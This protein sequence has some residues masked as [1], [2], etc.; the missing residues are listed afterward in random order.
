MILHQLLCMYGKWMGL[1]FLFVWLFVFLDCQTGIVSWLSLKLKK[2][3][4]ISHSWS[5]A[6]KWA[7]SILFKNILKFPSAPS[8]CLSVWSAFTLKALTFFLS[9]I[10]HSLTGALVT[11]LFTYLAGGT[12]LNPGCVT[13]GIRRKICSKSIMW[14]SPPGRP[15]TEPQFSQLKL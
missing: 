15:R 5:R 2:W 10:M 12:G 7:V 9:W 11:V 6:E 14:T 13:K 4:K 1:C 3:C 8:R